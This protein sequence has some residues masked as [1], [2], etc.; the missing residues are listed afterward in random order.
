MLSASNTK[1]GAVT[2]KIKDLRTEEVEGSRE[3]ELEVDYVFVATGYKRDAHVGMLAEV[4]DLLSEELRKEGKFAVERNYR[5]M[6]DD[7]KV[8][9][10]QAGIWLQ[11]CNEGTHGVSD[12]LEVW[13]AF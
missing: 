2:L 4:R 5:V 1:S 7:K 3:E 13:G 6:T 12:L 8:D 10:S 11:G 9:E